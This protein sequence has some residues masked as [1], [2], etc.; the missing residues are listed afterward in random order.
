[1]SGHSSKRDSPRDGC[2]PRLHGQAPAA[3]LLKEVWG[4]AA[5]AKHHGGEIVGAAVA[6]LAVDSHAVAPVQIA[7]SRHVLTV[8]PIGAIVSPARIA[9]SRWTAARWH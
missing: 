1:M 2:G 5:E 6:I 8:I 4:R 3:S 7:Q 9:A